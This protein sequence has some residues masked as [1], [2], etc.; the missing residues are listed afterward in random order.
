MSV[1][2][3]AASQLWYFD[4]MVRLHTIFFAAAMALGLV[5]SLPA[6]AQ[7]YSQDLHDQSRWRGTSAPSQHPPGLSGMDSTSAYLQRRDD[8][9]RE[10][11]EQVERQRRMMENFTNIPDQLRETYPRRADTPYGG[12]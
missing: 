12:R 10:R 9:E 1:G 11:R 4:R 5:V 6:Q 7:N 8:E 3:I 2:S